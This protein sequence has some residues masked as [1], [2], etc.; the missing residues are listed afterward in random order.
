MNGISYEV[1]TDNWQLWYALIF[2]FPAH[3]FVVDYLVQKSLSS[4]L[5]LMSYSYSK[6]N[7]TTLVRIR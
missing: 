2:L 5:K 3:T 4:K 7:S 1:Y 6:E